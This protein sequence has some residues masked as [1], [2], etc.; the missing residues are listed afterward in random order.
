[1][2]E[3]GGYV[4]MTYEMRASKIMARTKKKRCFFYIGP[5]RIE[6]LSIRTQRPFDYAGAY[7]YWKVLKNGKDTEG[8]SKVTIN[9]SW[10][11]EAKSLKRFF[12]LFVVAKTLIRC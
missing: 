8:V 3:N 12:L 7:T 10:N 6:T 4:I 5:N 9:G 11:F 2:G 1:M